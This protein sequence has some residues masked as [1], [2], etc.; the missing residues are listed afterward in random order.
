[1]QGQGRKKN[2]DVH[3]ISLL[4]LCEIMPG[5]Q[6]RLA[7]CKCLNSDNNIASLSKKLWLTYL[8]TYFY[9]RNFKEIYLPHV[10][11]FLLQFIVTPCT[12]IAVNF[13]VKKPIHLFRFPSMSSQ[14]KIVECQV[15]KREV[16]LRSPCITWNTAAENG[17]ERNAKT[18]C[19]NS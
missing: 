13:Y 19:I 15:G 8:L 9:F 10:L 5:L 12:L 4:P 3:E 16:L 11:A 6:F 2:R 14:V 1:M 17:R 18:L 7:K